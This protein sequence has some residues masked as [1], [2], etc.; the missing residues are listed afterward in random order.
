MQPKTLF[1][2]VIATALF[3]PALPA[4]PAEE[5]VALTVYNGGY[6]VVREI[7]QVDV[8]EHGRAQFQDVA[9]GIDAT[10]VHFKSLTDPTTKLLEQNYQYDLVSADKLLQKYIDRPI[11]VIGPGSA[12]KGRLLSFDKLQIVL[13]GEDGITMVQRP[14]NVRDIR[15]GP[16]PKGLLTRPTL[17]WLVSTREA[18][19]HLAEVTYQ[20]T[21]LNW[22]TEYVLVLGADDT[23]ADLSGWI[24]VE[25]QSGKRYHDARLKFV[26]G[27][28]HRVTPPSHHRINRSLYMKADEAESEPMQQKAFF[29]YHL[30]TLPR[31]STVADRE[32][33]QLEMFAPVSGLDVDKRFL[34]NPLGSIHLGGGR[35]MNREYG[36]SSHKKVQVFIQFKNEEA[37]GLGI[38]LPAGKVR[39]F[40]QD[41][42]DGALEFVGEER[43]D[44]TPKDEQISLR[45]GNAFDIVGQRRQTA[46]RTEKHRNWI[47]ESI[48]I[49]V[50]NHKKEPV[51]V[52]IKE[53]LYRWSNWQITASSQSYEKLD[54]RTI[55]FDVSVPAEGET[56]TSYTTEYSW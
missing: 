23:T 35:H 54:A 16:L 21:G 5:H 13:E 20:T 53:P 14:D 52:R 47:R 12:Y 51:I 38:P 25:N 6:G 4:N 22:H 7:R 50:R 33:K 2:A 26:A 36:A 18:G 55:A 29:E 48:E 1:R 3:A 49:V 31:R 41:P 32:V 45:V 27:D 39:V 43:I 46:F 15:F 34:Y 42:E 10:T 56:L 19:R 37:G 40:K 28:V 24:S 44:H 9:T 11:T 8:D 30:Y 17:R